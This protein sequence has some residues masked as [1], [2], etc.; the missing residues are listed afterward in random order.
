MKN[1]YI[2]QTYDE[3]VHDNLY[4]QMNQYELDSNKDIYKQVC[5]LAKRDFAPVVEVY[6]I[7]ARDYRKSWLHK[8][9]KF[10]EYECK[11]TPE[12]VKITYDL[13]DLMKQEEEEEKLKAKEKKDK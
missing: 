9:F 2:A 1:Y 11:C 7:S 6:A 12:S 4:L 8:K 3:C 10:K 5:I 13:Y